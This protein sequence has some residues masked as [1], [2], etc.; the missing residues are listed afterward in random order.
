MALTRRTARL[1][2][3]AAA[4]AV[5]GLAPWV[6][7]NAATLELSPTGQPGEYYLSFETAAVEGF[8]GVLLGMAV[9]EVEA[10][11]AELYPDAP[12]ERDTDPVQLTPIVH[13]TLEEL[14]PVPGAPALGPATITYIF[15]AHSEQLIAINVNWYAR[16]DAT[17]EERNAILA[18]GTA[19]VAEMMQYLWDPLQVI[20]GVVTGPND[21]LLFAGR[22]FEGRGVEVSVSGVPL[23]VIILPDGI[24]EHRPVQ[25]GPARLRIALALA[26][27]DPEVF[28]I[29]PGDF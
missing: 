14:A 26:P 18:A 20:H 8:D 21:V 9:P 22:D 3:L 15:G 7:A 29:P 24:E 13:V 4:V 11:V 10:K 2:A 17:P 6:P 28:T 27:D 25:G 16:G 5:F 12:V 19:Y 23:D 1:A